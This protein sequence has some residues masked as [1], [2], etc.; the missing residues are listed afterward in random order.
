MTATMTARMTA[1]DFVLAVGSLDLAALRTHHV[2]LAA[3]TA[4]LAK[5][6]EMDW[7]WTPDDPTV[8]LLRAI[9]R[10][11]I[12]APDATSERATALRGQIVGS[13]RRAPG[14]RCPHPSVGA[15]T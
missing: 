4:E 3:V 1:R 7:P 12:V 5:D 13:H 14:D 11:A 2:D 15:E 9:A 10:I 6:A 8:A